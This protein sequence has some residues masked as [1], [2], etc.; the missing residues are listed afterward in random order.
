M[1]LFS[2]IR[3]ADIILVIGLIVVGLIASCFIF[4]GSSKGDK[5]VITV[6]GK[7]YGQY[8]LATDNEIRIRQKNAFNTVVIKDGKVYMSEA[9]C[10]GHDCI[11]QGKK[12][13]T[14][15]TIVCL[16]HKVLIEITGGTD[17][18]DT[19]SQ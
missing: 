4:F 12:S 15:Q 1:K 8:S 11:H 2:I 16:P 5:V 19:I 3:K 9:N 18:Y 13:Q 6:A 17:K 14:Q 7:E 10:N